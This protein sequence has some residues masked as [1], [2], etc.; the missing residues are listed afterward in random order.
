MVNMKKFFVVLFMMIII[1]VQS[2]VLVLGSDFNADDTVFDEVT[3]KLDA[4]GIIERYDDPIKLDET[5][6]RG[7]MIT[8]VVRLLGLGDLGGSTDQSALVDIAVNSGIISG[9]GNGELGLDDSITYEQ[10]VKMLVNAVG[11]DVYAQGKGGYPTGY[12]I[13]GAENGITKGVYANVGEQINRK[14]A[15]S[16]SYKKLNVDL[17]ERVGS[18]NDERFS[19]IRNRTLLTERLNVEENSGILTATS[20]TE[21][22]KAKSTLKDDEVKIGDSI[23]KI[24]KTDAK[25]YLGYEVDFY[26]KESEGRNYKELIFIEKK[27]NYNNT[28][29]VKA[30]SIDRE[31]T[32]RRN[33]VNSKEEGYLKDAKDIKI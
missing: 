19:V 14:I 16:L 30:D 29:T 17:M 18:G 28:I 7:E 1:T 13:V 3:V 31:N 20:E 26:A 27:P 12:L 5:V 15:A 10:A 21:L 32:T 25:K 8:I 11:Y 9:Y 22:V 6:T 2:F 23:Y 24:G 33:F 4:L